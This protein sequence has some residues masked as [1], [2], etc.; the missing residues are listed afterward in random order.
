MQLH[1]CNSIIGINIEREANHMYITYSES[2]LFPDE[3]CFFVH[4]ANQALNLLLPDGFSSD[5]VQDEWIIKIQSRRGRGG[6]GR[7]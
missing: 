6:E 5:T 4:A 3:I 7:V 1:A 2:R